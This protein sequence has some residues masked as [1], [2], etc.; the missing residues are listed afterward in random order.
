[1]S[2]EANLQLLLTHMQPELLGGEFVF[3]SISPKTFNQLCFQPIGWF[4]ESEGITLVVERSIADDEGLPYEFISRMITLN[5]H[6][7]LEAV[8]FLAAITSKLAGAGISVNTIS[9][10]YHDHLFVP[11]DRAVAVMQ[12]LEELSNDAAGKIG[13]T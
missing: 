6:S 1:M 9:A 3:C 13:G 4:R 7:S 8:G 2:G 10:F 5:V 11:A 12:L